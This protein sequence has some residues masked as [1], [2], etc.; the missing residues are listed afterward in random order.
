MMCAGAVSYNLPPV[1]PGNEGSR[2]CLIIGVFILGAC[3]YI[4]ILLVVLTVACSLFA[5]RVFLIVSNE[6]KKIDAPPSTG[7]IERTEN[8][9][10][11]DI[12]RNRYKR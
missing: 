5:P 11:L 10:P 1:K 9:A 8:D 7:I 12:L 2:G 4:Q 3:F 6:W